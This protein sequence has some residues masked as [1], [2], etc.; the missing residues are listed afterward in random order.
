MNSF[1]KVTNLIVKAMNSFTKV[2][3]LSVKTTNSIAKT[4]YYTTNIIQMLLRTYSTPCLVPSRLARMALSTSS[5]N[6]SSDD[7]FG[8]KFLTELQKLINY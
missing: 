2:T 4:N 1:I 8:R 3:C 7:S 5:L 6:S